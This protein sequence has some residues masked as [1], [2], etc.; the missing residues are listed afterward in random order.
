MNRAQLASIR[1]RVKSVYDENEPQ[2]FTRNLTMVELLPRYQTIAANAVINHALYPRGAEITMR[3]WPDRNVEPINDVA[4]L[5]AEYYARNRNAPTLPHSPYNPLL[6]TIYL[7]A[8]LPP[9]APKTRNRDSSERLPS[10]VIDGATEAMPKY[11]THYG[12]RIG[13]YEIDEGAQFTFLGWPEDGFEPVNEPA[14]QVCSYLKANKSHPELLPAPWCCYRQALVLPEL[15]PVLSEPGLSR[16]AFAAPLHA[17]QSLSVRNSR[18]R[19]SANR[20]DFRD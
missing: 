11:R 16:D 2:P 14:R 17:A 4:R 8:V 18:R 1:S 7:P 9:S 10:P 20:A 12:R 13:K 19:R 15:P 5:V 3:S 6:G